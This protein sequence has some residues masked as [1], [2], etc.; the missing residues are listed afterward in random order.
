MRQ[1]FGATCLL[2]SLQLQRFVFSCTHL[3][4]GSNFSDGRGC[5]VNGDSRKAALGQPD[6]GSQTSDTSPDDPY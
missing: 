1:K 3:D 2:V 5:F 4:S 6:R